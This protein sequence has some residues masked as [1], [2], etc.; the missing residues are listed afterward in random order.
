MQPLRVLIVED[1]ALI[2]VLLA[3]LLRG[4]G[5]EVCDTARTEAAAVTAAERCAPDLMIVDARLGLGSGIA[6]VEEILRARPV[7][8]FFVSG[9]ADR[10]RV[11]RPDAVVLR[12]PFRK[13]DL[14]RAIALALA[15]VAAPT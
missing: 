7:P 4:M 9:D 11:R 12:K 3:E 6:A 2:G 5:H 13:A 8:H 15:A 1:D 10:V 14:A